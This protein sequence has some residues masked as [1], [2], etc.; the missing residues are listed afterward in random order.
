[1]TWPGDGRP[2]TQTWSS[3][4]LCSSPQTMLT[5]MTSILYPMKKPFLERM[6]IEVGFERRPGFAAGNWYSSQVEWYC[7]RHGAGGEKIMFREQE[8]SLA[9][10]FTFAFVSFCLSPSTFK[11][12]L[13]LPVTTPTLLSFCHLT[14]VLIMMKQASAIL[15][16]PLLPVTLMGLLC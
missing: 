13:P 11:P 10:L 14:Q 1:M 9:D 7:H 3:S 2:R 4:V 8:G 5:L 16:A 15:D 12:S 6:G